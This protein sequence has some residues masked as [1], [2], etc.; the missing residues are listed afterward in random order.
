[1]PKVH[2]ANLP[3]HIGRRKRDLQPRSD[4]L[5]VHLVDI[6]Y[7]DRHPHALVPLLISVLL[8]GGGVRAPAAASLRPQAKKDTGLLTRSN[9][10]KRRRRS[11]SP[12]ISSIPTS[13]TKRPCRQCRRRSKS[14]SNLWLP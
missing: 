5:L 4:A 12:T 14:E 1:M 8:K 3:R 6:V 13:Q 11:P 9:C 10:A 2:L 7:P